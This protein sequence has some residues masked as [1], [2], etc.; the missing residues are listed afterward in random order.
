MKGPPL[1][2]W[3]ARSLEQPVVWI[4][5]VPPAGEEPGVRSRPSLTPPPPPT[6]PRAHSGS[7]TVTSRLGCQGSGR[8]GGVTWRSQASSPQ[9]PKRTT[10][11]ISKSET[12][13]S[14]RPPSPL[15]TLGVTFR[16]PR[17]WGSSES[18]RLGHPDPAP[19]SQKPRSLRHRER[20][21]Q[22]AP[23]GPLR[24]RLGSRALPPR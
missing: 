4:S 14:S 19:Y 22:R 5:G 12:L 18:G 7:H 17:C 10:S 9:D 6:P 11:I 13:S 2:T 24:Q 21:V 8:G 16:R 1:E 15:V 20:P 3:H 23:P